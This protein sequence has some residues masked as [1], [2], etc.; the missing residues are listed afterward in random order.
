VVGLAPRALTNCAPSAPSDTSAR[1][2]NFT[3]SCHG[4]R[5]DDLAFASFQALRQE[6]FD[7][8]CRKLGLSGETSRVVEGFAVVSATA[9]NVRVFFEH[10]RGLCLFGLGAAP[11]ARPLCSVEEM[12]G[13]FPRVRVLAEGLQRLS[14]SEQQR[15]VEEHWPDLQ[16]MF[17][18]E[19]MHETRAWH[20]AVVKE[21]T[22]RFSRGS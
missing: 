22:A 3:V 12:A 21:T 19:H 8:L 13:R 18:S 5:T 11:D 1:P 14:L 9:G 20:Q 6:H 15:F 16:V 17:S 2:L 10:D 4:M 7:T